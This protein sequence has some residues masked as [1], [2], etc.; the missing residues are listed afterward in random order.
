MNITVH[1]K[2]ENG[3]YT[4]TID[5][6]DFTIPDDMGNR[7]RRMLSEWEAEG[8]KLPEYIK[9]SPSKEDVN[10]ERNKRISSGIPFNG[11]VYDFDQMGKDNITGA[12]SLAKFALFAG[13]GEGNFRWANPDV[14]FTWITQ[15]NSKVALDAPTMSKLGDVAAGWTT[16][17]IYAARALKDMNPIPLDYTADEYW[18]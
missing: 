13:A 16:K 18:P 9:P 10:I 12:A 2:T 7:Y 14:D 6:V 4:A 3:D 17:H 11:K 8:N 15:D 5:G 1:S